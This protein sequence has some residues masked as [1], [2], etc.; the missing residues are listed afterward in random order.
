MRAVP[1]VAIFGIDGQRQFLPDIQVQGEDFECFIFL[2]RIP[3]ESELASCFCRRLAERPGTPFFLVV[4]AELETGFY[5]AVIVP[6]DPVH[7]NDGFAD[8]HENDSLRKR[9]ASN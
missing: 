7:R 3:P 5:H 9:G 8:F 4:D 2:L 6:D 1:V